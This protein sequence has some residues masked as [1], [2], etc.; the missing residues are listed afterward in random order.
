MHTFHPVVDYD[1]LLLI[2]NIDALI[3]FE[4]N[5]SPGSFNVNNGWVGARAKQKKKTTTTIEEN[6]YEHRWILQGD[7]HSTLE[8]VFPRD[9]KCSFQETLVSVIIIF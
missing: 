5:G 2:I 3:H 4:H 6:K 1:Y 9:Y 8:I 7:E